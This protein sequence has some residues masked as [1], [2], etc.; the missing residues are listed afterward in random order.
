MSDEVTKVVNSLV[1]KMPEPQEHAIEAEEKKQEVPRD[2]FDRDGRP[3]D[4][5]IHEKQID[6]S[7]ILNR[8]GTLRI[9]RG[10]G[11][12]RSVVGET[13]RAAGGP[14]ATPAS[15]PIE[16]GKQISE[17][18]FAFGQVLGGDEFAPVYN[19]ELGINERAQMYDAWSRYCESKGINDIPPGIAIIIATGGYIIPRFAMPKTKTRLTRVKDWCSGKLATWRNH[20]AARPDRGNDRKRQDDA[21]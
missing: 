8:D 17:A 14:F 3:F 10:R 5:A 11:S 7:P 13:R 2:Y 20:R 6:G 9:K 19:K 12:P 15:T 21:G 4:P 18:I 1:D 16:A